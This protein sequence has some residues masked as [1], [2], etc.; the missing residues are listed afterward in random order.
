MLLKC[1]CAGDNDRP[2][3]LSLSQRS[4]RFSLSEGALCLSLSQGS[5]SLSHG[6]EMIMC[7]FAKQSLIFRF[8]CAR[9]FDL[10]VCLICHLF[11]IGVPR[12]P[13]SNVSFICAVDDVLVKIQ[14]EEKHQGKAVACVFCVGQECARAWW[15]YSLR[16]SCWHC[17]E[18]F[19]VPKHQHHQN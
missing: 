7:T 4:F 5:F 15:H 3:S 17:G 16:C 12:F 6:F 13:F 9:E 10:C 19:N 18:I 11:C 14:C 8:E 1:L 2:A